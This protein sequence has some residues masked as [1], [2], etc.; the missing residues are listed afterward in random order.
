MSFCREGRDSGAWGL[1]LPAACGGA[2]RSIGGGPEPEEE[3]A[4]GLGAD[5]RCHG[6][7]QTPT[8][9]QN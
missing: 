2:K 9:H 8:D 6:L 4:G 5:V 1:E 3:Q 7:H